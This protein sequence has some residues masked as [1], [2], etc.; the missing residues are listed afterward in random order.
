M[1]LSIVLALAACVEEGDPVGMVRSARLAPDT[2]RT[3]EMALSAY[4]LFRNPVWETYVDA[5]GRA[6]V[7]FVAEYD[8]SRGVADCPPV[9]PEVKPAARVFVTLRYVLEGGAVSLADGFIEA[10]STTG[11]SAKYLAESGTVDRI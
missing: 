3:V 2:G 1:L 11:Y 4:S 5:D 7:R 10:Y 8:V 9:G 6:V